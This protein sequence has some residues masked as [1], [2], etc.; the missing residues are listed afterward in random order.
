M[1]WRSYIHTDEEI[2]LGKLV[3]KPSNKPVKA[4]PAP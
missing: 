2:L 4:R 1:N 3:V